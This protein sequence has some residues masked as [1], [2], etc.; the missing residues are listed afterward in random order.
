MKKAYK[1]LFLITVFLV[2]FTSINTLNSF[3]DNQNDVPYLNV[4]DSTPPVIIFDISDMSSNGILTILVYDVE[5][6]LS[7]VSIYWNGIE[8]ND[9]TTG[10]TVTWSI[11]NY[12]ATPP[13][14][15][16]IN[17]IREN[18]LED[19]SPGGGENTYTSD[20]EIDQVFE[21]GGHNDVTAEAGNI[22]S[23][24]TIVTMSFCNSI[25]CW[26]RGGGSTPTDTPTDTLEVQTGTPT[27]IF[28]MTGYYCCG[29]IEP[30]IEPNGS[31]IDN[32]TIFY[33]QAENILSFSI[34]TEDGYNYK[35]GI[36]L[37]DVV[38]LNLF[39]CRDC[40]CP[41]DP[42]STSGYLFITLL[43][44]VIVLTAVVNFRKHK[45]KK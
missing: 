27:I 16:L 38:D 29:Y 26:G 36:M 45:S 25:D 28:N 6:A 44:S 42:T 8:I 30:M 33:D 9:S 35:S 20:I 43:S 22:D 2:L 14:L 5:T 18:S 37:D 32:F 21:T 13:P 12:T 7:E 41:I 11:V 19:A 24:T 3:P 10:V 23:T 17:E 15:S 4:G 31:S 39:G 34:S 40:S 1:A